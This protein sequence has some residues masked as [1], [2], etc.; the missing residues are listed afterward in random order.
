MEPH[1]L[2]RPVQSAKHEDDPTVLPQV[3][4]GLGTAACIILIRHFER[5]E[6][7]EGL[8]AFGRCV[9][10]SARRKRRRPNEKD[11][12][13]RNPGCEFRV[14]MIVMLAH[15]ARPFYCIM[16]TG[17]NISFRDTMRAAA[18]LTLRIAFAS[19]LPPRTLRENS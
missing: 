7:A 8:A 9:D 4:G 10:V 13:S 12:L 19:V 3:G 2:G 18:S 15:R 16:Q 14:D 1:N 6:N 11:A 5:P 17:V